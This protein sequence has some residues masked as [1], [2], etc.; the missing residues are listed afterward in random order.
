[1]KR[2]VSD[3]SLGIFV[4]FLVSKKKDS[5]NQSLFLCRRTFHWARWLV[6]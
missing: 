1:M 3:I 6:L 5:K 2:D 4:K